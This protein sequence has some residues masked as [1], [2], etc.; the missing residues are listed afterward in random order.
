[1]PI[2]RGFAIA[3]LA[4]ALLGC[5]HTA[6]AQDSTAPP[7]PAPV[8]N[9]DQ[10]F[11]KYVISAVGPPGIIGAAGAAG[12]EHWQNYPEEWR[13]GMSGYMKRWASAYAAGAI[14]DSTKYA[15]AHFRHEDPSFARCTCRG[16]KNRMRHAVVSVFTART[17]D[18]RTVFSP[19]TVAGYAAEHAIPAV[20]WFP[21]ERRW[22]EGVGLLGASIGSKI[23]VN[24]FRE[25]FGRPRLVFEHN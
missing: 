20:L 12:F 18:G 6:A 25:F 14:G 7:G 11:R 23:G 21:P 22:T 15:V 5:P 3:A 8:L 10:L 1:V 16:F 9:D 17:R 4:C 19:A 24:I 13:Q 2:V